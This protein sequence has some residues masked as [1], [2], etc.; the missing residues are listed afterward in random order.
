MCFNCLRFG[1]CANKCY[2]KGC[3]KCSQKHNVL[4]HVEN[5]IEKNEQKQ[6]NP[7]TLMTYKKNNIVLLSTVVVKILD[8]NGREQ[9]CRLIMDNGSMSN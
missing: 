3:E 5:K 4:L 6:E 9:N 8:R 2:F 7:V 1:H